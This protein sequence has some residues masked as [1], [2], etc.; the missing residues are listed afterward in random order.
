[1]QLTSLTFLSVLI[2]NDSYL[3]NLRL[4]WF[5]VSNK[6]GD[7]EKQQ[8]SRTLKGGSPTDS[9]AVSGL[10]N[11]RCSKWIEQAFKAKKGLKNVQN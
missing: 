3:G 5:P 1:M 4:C 9:G 2:I 7:V 8:P 6:C 10:R 11:K